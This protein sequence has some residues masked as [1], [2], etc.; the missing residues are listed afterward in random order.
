MPRG[1]SSK[2]AA[3]FLLSFFKCFFI[4]RTDTY[5]NLNVSDV[6]LKLSIGGCQ[7]QS[8]IRKAF[9]F[10]E[11]TIVEKYSENFITFDFGF[12]EALRLT[13]FGATFGLSDSFHP[14]HLVFR[15]EKVK[16]QCGLSRL[17]KLR[18][19]KSGSLECTVEA[20]FFLSPI[21]KKQSFTH[22]ISTSLIIRSTF[23]V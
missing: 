7:T 9:F 17:C 22:I 15:R 21:S 14:I 11:F 5:W 20:M 3:L 12:D 23:K 18:D 10:S 4:N 1:R 19:K 16:S 2:P 13:I 8:L 6:L